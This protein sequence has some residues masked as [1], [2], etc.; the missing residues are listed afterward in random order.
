MT[1]VFAIDKPLD[2]GKH[3]ENHINLTDIP[4]GYIFPERELSFQMK[5]H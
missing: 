2:R 5:V 1:E 4:L 3:S